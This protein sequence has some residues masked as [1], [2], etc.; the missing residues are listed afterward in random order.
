M[1][2]AI[3]ENERTAYSRLVDSEVVLA[4]GAGGFVEIL[5]RL[6]SV[7]P[8]ELIES[9][10]R[11][12]AEGV[13]SKQLAEKICSDAARPRAQS[14]EVRSLLPLPHPLDFEWR[15]AANTSRDLLNLATYLA[16]LDGEVLLFRNARARSRGAVASDH[17]EDLLFGRRQ[18]RHPAG[19][20]P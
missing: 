13:I 5:R 4:V 14:P 12:T 3:R 16:P 6:P 9:I 19:A 15:Y 7:Y 2:T 10:G 18:C 11:L 8:T 17:A 1:I 20:S